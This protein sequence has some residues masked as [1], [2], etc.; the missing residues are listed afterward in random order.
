MKLKKNAFQ[1]KEVKLVYNN[2]WKELMENLIKT[3]I[4]IKKMVFLYSTKIMFKKYR[5]NIFARSLLGM[6]SKQRDKSVVIIYSVN[7]ETYWYT[8]EST[9]EKSRT[10][11]ISAA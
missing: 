2:N 1:G 3:I 9:Q 7:E 4:R 8:K 5:K 6:T 10:H 11:A